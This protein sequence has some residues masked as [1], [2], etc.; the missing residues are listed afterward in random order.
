MQSLIISD[1]ERIGAVL[2]D[3]RF[4]VPPPAPGE[5]GGL[6]WVRR[7]VARFAEGGTHER[8]RALAVKELAALDPA[9]LREEARRTTRA[10]LAGGAEPADLPGEV[11]VRVLGAALG[12]RDVDAFAAAVP[13]VAAGYLT[14]GEPSEEVDAAVATLV[15]LL[16]PG[17]DEE[18]AAR[19]GLPL[20]AYA[21]TAKLA[22]SAIARA[23]EAGTADEA[24]ARAFEEDPP[25]PVMRRVTAT[26]VVVDGETVPAET[27]VELVSI[28]RETAFATGRRP[29]PAEAHALA[30]V[31]GII[32]EVLAR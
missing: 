5:T 2:G 10:L 19:I 23:H 20:Q 26:E 14:G 30:I 6:A 21:A 32:E 9:V 1:P 15:D 12:V 25:V 28:G 31:N 7:H 16:G 11:P 18:V 4:R 13:I 22:A 27:L 3:E 8:R 24:V 17:D 29:C